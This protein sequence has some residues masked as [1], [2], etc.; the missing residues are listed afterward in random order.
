MK[1]VVGLFLG[2]E[3]P[4][5][6]IPWLAKRATPLVEGVFFQEMNT[7]TRRTLKYIRGKSPKLDAK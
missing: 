6:T 1:G 7:W 5:L 2:S 3:A 4:S